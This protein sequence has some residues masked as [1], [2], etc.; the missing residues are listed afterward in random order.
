MIW[1]IRRV[2]KEK[3]PI[4]VVVV[5]DDIPSNFIAEANKY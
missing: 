2:C 5:V 3:S 4:F 1:N